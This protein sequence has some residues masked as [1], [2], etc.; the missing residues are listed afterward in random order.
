[1]AAINPCL[2]DQIEISA[3]ST[4]GDP[5]SVDIRLGVISLRIYEDI[6]SPTLTAQVFMAIAGEVIDG[7]GLYNGLPVRGGE[8]V[9][10]KIAGN[11]EENKGFDF[12]T[13]DT[14][15]YVSAVNKYL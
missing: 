5:K 3:E 10:I 12:T 2:Y 14:Y 4:S 6:F 1:M 11:S 13:P 15:W 9:S 7:K 8:R